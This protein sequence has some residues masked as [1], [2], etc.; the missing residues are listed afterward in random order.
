[1]GQVNNFITTD[2]SC[3]H[4]ENFAPM[5]AGAGNS[6]TFSVDATLSAGTTGAA[7]STV[8]ANW[9]DGSSDTM[10]P[11]TPPAF[12]FAHTYASAGSYQVKVVVTLD[13][14]ETFHER[15]SVTVS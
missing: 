11:G 1:M 12:S 8:V 3:V 10:T 5:G 9:G 6:T 14:G 7:I 4:I 13:N 2:A 15:F